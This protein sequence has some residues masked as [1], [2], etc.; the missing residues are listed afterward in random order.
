MSQ[1]SIEHICGHKEVVQIYGPTKE[2]QRKA[3][4]MASRKCDACYEAEQKAVRAAQAELAAAASQQAGLPE[5]VGSEKQIP[6]AETIRKALIDKLIPYESRHAEY[7]ARIARMESGAEPLPA[8]KT[9]AHMAEA[10][11]ELAF[12]IERCAA[13]RAERSAKWFIDHRDAD[14]RELMARPKIGAL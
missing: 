6:W 11:A 2:R 10:K 14:I 8:G 3:D 9:A 13:I 12:V 1:Y 7:S 5:L 4:W